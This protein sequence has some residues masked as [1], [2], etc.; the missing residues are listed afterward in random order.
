MSV[1]SLIM[2]TAGF[3]LNGNWSNTGLSANFSCTI[4]LDTIIAGAITNEGILF[5]NNDVSSSNWQICVSLPGVNGIRSMTT[6]FPGNDFLYVTTNDGKIYK[7]N[8]K[9]CTYTIF[10]SPSS[11]TGSINGLTWANG[12][13]AY[14][15]GEDGKIFKTENEGNTWTL[16][17]T[18]VTTYLNDIYAA[19]GTE[20]VYV[21]GDMGTVLATGNGGTSWTQYNP[22]APVWLSQV[23]NLGNNNFLISGSDG[24]LSQWNGG[25]VFTPYNTGTTEGFM[26]YDGAFWGNSPYQGINV[27]DNG[28]FSFIN[29]DYSLSPIYQIPITN[30]YLNDVSTLTLPGNK[31][32]SDSLIAFAAGNTGLYRYSE[33]YIPTGISKIEVS[34]IKIHPN[35]VRDIVNIQLS[36][37]QTI[38]ELSLLDQFG[39]KIIQ[40]FNPSVRQIDLTGIPAGFYFLRIDLGNKTFSQKLIK[41]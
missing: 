12:S 40:V 29:K 11:Y 13:T 10:N 35:P 18:G 30:D 32:G 34:G 9:Q 8:W 27:G 39:R 23:S 25:S 15:C 17:N 33:P 6:P 14:I 24:F 1:F 19:P 20:N 16:Q 28:T 21:V 31:S 38:S 37:N 7:I 2:S 3:S 4:S 5:I 36:R 41:L 26:G 22:G